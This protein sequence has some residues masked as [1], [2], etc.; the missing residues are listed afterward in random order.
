[1][2]TACAMGATTR[3]VA[4]VAAAAV[5]AACTTSDNRVEDRPPVSH[6]A[7]SH[8]P[9]QP[10]HDDAARPLEQPTAID[11]SDPKAV[12][13]ALILEGLEE[14]GLEVTDLGVETVRA[15]AN[16]VTVR[17][18]VTHEASRSATRHTSIYELGL[19]RDRGR[20]WNL[21]GFRQTQ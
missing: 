16:D 5:L 7:I 15:R 8:L 4:T 10:A 18:A 19:R 1:M 6:V 11:P 9:E 2:V 14:Q 20:S 17:V 21:V 13:A 12:A 3:T